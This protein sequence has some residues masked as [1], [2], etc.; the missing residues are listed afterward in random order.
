M[1]VRSRLSESLVW[2]L[3]ERSLLER[4][5]NSFHLNSREAVERPPPQAPKEIGAA[6]CAAMQVKAAKFVN[7]PGNRWLTIIDFAKARPS[8][9]PMKVKSPLNGKRL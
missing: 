9:G 8:P 7:A 4:L 3:S 5:G 6:S 2:L 1:H